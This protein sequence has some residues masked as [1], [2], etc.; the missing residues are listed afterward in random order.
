MIG[1]RLFAVDQSAAMENEQFCMRIL[2]YLLLS[3]AA[4]IA[5]CAILAY[6][7]LTSLACGYA[8]RASS[9]HASPGEL[10]SDDRFWLIGLPSGMVTILVVSGII[11]RRKAQQK[12]DQ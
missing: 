3:A 6:G 12:R 9:C 11:T 1:R 7:Y 8:P 2:S 5:G 10:G 4:V